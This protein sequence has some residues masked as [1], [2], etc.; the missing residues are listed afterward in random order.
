[1]KAPILIVFALLSFATAYGQTKRE[2]YVETT[3]GRI[4][5]GTFLRG[6]ATTIE[7]ETENGVQSLKIEKI[8]NIRF[9]RVN[10]AYA[11]GPPGANTI[12]YNNPRGLSYHSSL[13]CPLASSN[14][15]PVP[16]VEASGL[17]CTKCDPPELKEV[18][19]TSS[20]S[21]LPS[22]ATQSSQSSSERES[23]PRSRASGGAK[24]S[25]SSGYIRGPRGGCYY[26]NRNGNKTYVDRS[27][28]R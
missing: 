24:S 2:A 26:I 19:T 3:D 12:V 25:A 17:A 6:D 7:V 5:N 9:V 18:P 13:S 20:I 4:I 8:N 28:C 10:V 21:D 15:K 27:N 22:P 23:S 11:A 1:M 14:A 16:L